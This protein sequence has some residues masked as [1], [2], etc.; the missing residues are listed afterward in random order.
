MLKLK[1]ATKIVVWLITLKDA[2]FSNQ[3]LEKGWQVSA[4]LS[5]KKG[6]DPVYAEIWTGEPE[7]LAVSMVIKEKPTKDASY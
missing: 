4:V 2:I 5:R 1:D 3:H 7:N 6:A